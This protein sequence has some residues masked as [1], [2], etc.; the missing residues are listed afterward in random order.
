[1]QLVLSLLSLTHTHSHSR[2]CCSR[3]DSLVQTERIPD[4]EFVVDTSSLSP[5]EYQVSVAVVLG[6]QESVATGEGE[7]LTATDRISVSGE[8]RY[9]VVAVW[10]VGFCC[11]ILHVH[12]YV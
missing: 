6:D 4:T 1:M 10:R 2:A 7:A 3:G 5:G 9:Y 11:P 12:S 8:P